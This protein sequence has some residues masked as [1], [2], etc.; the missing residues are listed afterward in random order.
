ML[1]PEQNR[2][3]L[4]LNQCLQWL[5][6]AFVLSSACLCFTLEKDWFKAIPA[7]TK[8]PSYALL[9]VSIAFSFV[10]AV[11]DL[12]QAA[13]DRAGS[14]FQIH[15]QPMSKARQPFEPTPLIV[16]N[17]QVYLL[18]SVSFTVGALFGAIF[19]LVDVEDYYR[20]R[21]VLYTVLN[22]EI[23]LCEPIGVLFGAFAGFMSEFLRQQE[24]AHRIKEPITSHFAGDS[25]DEE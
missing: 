12:A 15:F 17:I 23:S 11:V 2:S 22:N 3:M 19:G 7:R 13:V 4:A 1:T 6:C 24:M 16:T 9:G 14:L 25:S 21:I 5:F 8:V 10:Y 20:N 18:L